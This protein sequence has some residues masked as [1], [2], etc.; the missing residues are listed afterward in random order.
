MTTSISRTPVR[1]GESQLG[2]LIADAQLAATRSPDRGNAQIAFMNPGGIRAD[3]QVPAGGGDITYGQLFSAQPFGN[4]LV[5]KSLT[6]AQ[7]RALLEQQFG[8]GSSS[9]ARPRVLAP[10]AGFTYR[11]NLTQP[12]G[13][14]V[15]DMHLHGIAIA[16]AE[17][18]R[19]TMNSY[20]ASGGD[21]FTVFNQGANA[22]GGSLDVD[23]FEAYLRGNA[24][25][26]PPPTNRIK[27]VD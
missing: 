4:S 20:L 1:S 11:Y 27:A 26:S 17:T 2:N 23:A 13:S 7:L 8:S 16:D 9:V 24:P 3:L 18:Y 12:A 22:L 5:V 19:V 14:R 21:N 25:I 10:S 6:G 15:S